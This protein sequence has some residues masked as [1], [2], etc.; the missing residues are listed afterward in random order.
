M[1][2]VDVMCKEAL[3]GDKEAWAAPRGYHQ[4]K[5]NAG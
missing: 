2:S 3:Y 5:G 1:R 4:D